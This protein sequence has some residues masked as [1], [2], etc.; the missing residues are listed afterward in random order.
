[1]WVYKRL[2]HPTGLGLSHR[3]IEINFDQGF[4]CVVLINFSKA[5]DTFNH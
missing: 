1:M 2:K 5:F 3:K 4:E